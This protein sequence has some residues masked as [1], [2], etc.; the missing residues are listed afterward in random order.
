MLRAP[1]ADCTTA[2]HAWVNEFKLA[3]YQQ[4]IFT[5]SCFQQPAAF[6]LLSPANKSAN[7]P[8]TAT[9]SWQAVGTFPNAPTGYDL[10]LGTSPNP[11]L[12]AANI[13][14]TQTTVSGLAMGTTYFWKVVAK[15]ACGNTSS[16]LWSFTTIPCT[17]PPRPFNYSSP[18]D[19]ATA[20][21][22]TVDLTWQASTQAASYQVYLGTAPGDLALVSTVS[23]TRYAA[24]GL[25]VSTTYYWKIVAQNSCGN[26]QGAVWS[27]TT[28]AADTPHHPRP[29]SPP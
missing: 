3:D 6:N 29:V 8:L 19:G 22:L 25:C 24:S 7:Q 11:P 9:L 27:F 23:G 12:Y 18:P 28:G 5:N 15:N 20:Q 14:G 16:A 4:I 10:Y 17:L 21:P 2:I 1:T 13:A 26:R